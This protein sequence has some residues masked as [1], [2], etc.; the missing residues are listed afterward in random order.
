MRI[1]RPVLAGDL[2]FHSAAAVL[3]RQLER[4]ADSF[5]I[6]FF[7]VDFAPSTEYELYTYPL[8]SRGYKTCEALLLTQA[9]E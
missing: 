4:L 6:R 8:Q 5:V 2:H 3:P 9:I 7:C 1:H